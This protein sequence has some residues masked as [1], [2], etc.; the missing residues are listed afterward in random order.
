VIA[1]VHHT[2]ILLLAVLLAAFWPTVA[3]ANYTVV[4]TDH[5]APRLEEEGFTRKTVFWPDSHIALENRAFGA[6]PAIV[7]FD[8]SG[9][10]TALM[11]ETQNIVAR[12]EYDPFG[13]LIGKW[14]ANADANRYRFSSKE[15]H[16]QSG[17]Y[18]YGFR[19]YD[20]NF[21]RWLNR[22]PIEELGGINLFAFVGNRA[23]NTVDPLGLLGWGDFN[24]GLL[25]D[26]QA[27]NQFGADLWQPI[28]HFFAGDLDNLNL[29]PDSQLTL[30]QNEGIGP[31]PYYDANGNRHRAGDIVM[32]EIVVP[33]AEN[34]VM[35]A[36]GGSEDKTLYEGLS[37]AGKEVKA[38]EEVAAVEEAAPCKKLPRFNGPKP[39][40]VENSA[41]VR[42]PT[43]RP[44]KTPLPSDAQ[45]VFENAVPNDPVNPRAWFGRNSDGQIYRYSVDNNGT[46]HF[47]GI[48][49]VGSGTPNLTQ[50]AR[51]RL[52]GQ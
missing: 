12:Y 48:D 35:M 43:L 5:T 37:A 8:G 32:D 23:V 22:D 18:Y 20:P 9:N 28:K 25:F 21:Q 39:R 2:V 44:G 42:G 1:R 50:Y 6:K 26:K 30:A 14:G 36:L 38:A 17:T 4:R 46:A 16:P 51:D 11:D 34:V 52:S 15:I 3:G 49:G 33:A 40:Y 29:G 7:F 13:R 19:F 10:V 45:A 47:S 41:H 24:P 27:L 31:T